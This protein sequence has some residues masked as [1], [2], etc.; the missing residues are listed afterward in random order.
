LSS[1]RVF[2]LA[3]G[4]NLSRRDFFFASSSLAAGGTGIPNLKK[5]NN[6]F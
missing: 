5:Q 4:V 6:K 1:S 2:D 3:A